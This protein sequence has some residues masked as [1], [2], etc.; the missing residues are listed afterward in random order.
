MRLFNDFTNQYQQI[1]KPFKGQLGEEEV[2]KRTA[3][4]FKVAVA[5]EKFV[6]N[7]SRYHLNR[8]KLLKNM[9]DSRM[10]ESKCRLFRFVKFVD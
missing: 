6:L 9:T 3:A 10:G 7:Y 1:T 4:I 8:T 5:F 2:K